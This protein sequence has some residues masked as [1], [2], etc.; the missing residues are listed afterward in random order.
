MDFTKRINNRLKKRGFEPLNSRG[1]ISATIE[2]VITELILQEH[3][4]L[5][6][7]SIETY[8]S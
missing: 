7:K 6:D 8:L 1:L 4:L 5:I 2:D 3:N